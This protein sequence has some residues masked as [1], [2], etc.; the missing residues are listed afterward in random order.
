MKDKLN[1][2]HYLPN[3]EERLERLRLIINGRPVAIVLQ[4][5]SATTLEE[6]ITELKDC[7]ICYASI[8]YFWVIEKYI[9][10]KI[11]RNLSIVMCAAALGL[12]TE[13][14]NIISFLERQELNLLFSVKMAFH[15]A[16]MPQGFD[17]TRFMAKYDEGLLLF[18]CV[19]PFL[20]DEAPELFNR[21][22]SAEFPLH[23]VAANSLSALL[24]L[25][26]IGKA[27][28]VVIFGADG[29]R[30][31]PSGL[32]FRESEL[33]THRNPGTDQSLVADT[34]TFNIRMLPLLR[35]IYQIYNLKPVEIINCSE[36]SHYTPFRKLSYNEAFD[37]LK[38]KNG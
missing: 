26:V 7:D 21:F 4:G 16:A 23:F 1:F 36:R 29:G 3:T 25:I 34:K 11:N 38:R 22:P 6:R 5:Y 30:V 9:L 35:K 31:D 28:R 32:Y 37:L 33:D 12:G 8:N 24:S 2:T 18:D 14:S 27:S 19:Y 10:E 13:I 20:C 17:L 15:L